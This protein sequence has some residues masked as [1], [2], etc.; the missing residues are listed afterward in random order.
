MNSEEYKKGGS[1]II[2][3]I[4]L[5]LNASLMVLGIV[6]VSIGEYSCE[7]INEFKWYN[8]SFIFVGFLEIVAGFLGHFIR[9]SPL[10]LFVYEIFLA[11]LFVLQLIFTVLVI[12]EKNGKISKDEDKDSIIYALVQTI[13]V[14]TACFVLGGWYWKTLENI[15]KPQRKT[16]KYVKN[17]FVKS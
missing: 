1:S 17:P 15:N 9:Y 11:I 10:R 5:I 13:I 4:L 7:K 14:I 3:G 6:V 12:T 2:F 8:G 16:E